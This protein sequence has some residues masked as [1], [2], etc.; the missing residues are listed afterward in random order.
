M[1]PEEVVVGD[2]KFLGSESSCMVFMLTILPVL[3]CSRWKLDFRIHFITWHI[4]FLTV[5]A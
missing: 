2:N 5:N 4:V 3:K 1:W